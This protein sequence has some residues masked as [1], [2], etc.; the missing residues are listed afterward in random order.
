M[1]VGGFDPDKALAKIKKLF[2]PI[3]RAE[4][5]RPQAGGRGQSATKPERL[6]MTSKFDV[7]RLLMGYNTVA[8]THPD[9]S[10]L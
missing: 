5:A 2:G 9:Y 7:P 10:A 6:E 1:I 3:P 8:M 4:V